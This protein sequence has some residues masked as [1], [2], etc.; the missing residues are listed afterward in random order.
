MGD[1]RI[2]TLRAGELA[3]ELAPS[4]GGGIVAF[5]SGAIDLMRPTAQADLAAGA[6]RQFASWP[7]V[8]WSNR[9]RG[10]RFAWRGR[11]IQLPV[12]ASDPHAIHGIGWRLPWTARD[13]SESAVCL[14][15]R[16][17]GD[18]RW[19]FAFEAQQCFALDA[20]G[21]ELWMSVTNAG[22]EPMPA[23]L[24]HHPYFPRDAETTLQFTA[25]EAFEN[26]ADVVGLVVDD[27]M[28]GRHVVRV[29]PP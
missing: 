12:D 6:V 20:D 4:L 14:V 9:I 7:L 25:A 21:F 24:G 5:R 26:D 13:A 17:A 28:R 10:G 11:Q 1:S 8:P 27:E 23:G 3:L 2:L 15:L 19:P 18:A 16:H 29:A 22:D